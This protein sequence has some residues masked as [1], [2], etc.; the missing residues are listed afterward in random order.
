MNNIDS[1]IINLDEI[2]NPAYQR[3]NGTASNLKAI[4]QAIDRKQAQLQIEIFGE[5][6]DK[7]GDIAAEKAKVM[8]QD[9]V[10]IPNNICNA[11]NDK[12]PANVLVINMSSSLMCPSYYFGICTIT[13]G[14]C[15]AQRAENQYPETRVQRQ[16]TDIMHTQM[17][18]MYQKGNKTPMRDYFRLIEHYIQ[19]GHAYADNLYREKVKELQHLERVNGKSYGE[20]ALASIKDLCDSYKIQH[21]RLNETGDFQCQL[22]VDLWA[23]FADKINRKYGIQT[24]AYTAR[25]LDFTEAGKHMSINYSHDSKNMN[26]NP[27]K[28]QAISTELWESLQGGDKVDHKT[29][30][31]ILG[32]KGSIFFYKCPC[33]RGATHCDEC[34]VC[35]NKNT[36]GEPYTIF[37]KYHGMLAA[38]GLKNLFKQS[39]VSRVVEKL[40]EHG[41]LTDEEFD[42]YSSDHNQERLADLS[43]KIDNQRQAPVRQ[44]GKAKKSGQTT[45]EPKP[46]TKTK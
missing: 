10:A 12:L 7:L 27:R 30:Q 18:Q 42:I 40:R 25:N 4:W 24:H 1:T 39:E 26:E 21:I 6:N 43:Q 17:L 35:F 44:R 11:G 38:N 9:K 29:H 46:S 31:P 36:T 15:Y 23:K 34:Q 22:A 19:L 28:F 37:V 3:N 14:A 32:K 45:T 16:Q 8:G 2:A 13:N 41:W 33:E 20:G 5:L